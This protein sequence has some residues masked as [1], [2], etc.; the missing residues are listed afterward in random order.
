MVELY[1]SGDTRLD[2]EIPKDLAKVRKLQK[3]KQKAPKITKAKK[4]IVKTYIEEDCG[5][6]G[7]SYTKHKDEKK[8]ES[9]GMFL[10]SQCRS[11]W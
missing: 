4:S 2:L 3:E 7:C 10:C 8:H 5:N 1:N 11:Q 9:S 6:C